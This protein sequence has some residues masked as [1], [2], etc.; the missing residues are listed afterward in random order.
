MLPSTQT[1]NAT[2]YK[3]CIALNPENLDQKSLDQPGLQLNAGEGSKLQGHLMR[4]GAYTRGHIWGYDKGCYKGPRRLGFVSGT[5]RFRVAARGSQGKLG[6][7]WHVWLQALKPE[8]QGA[9]G[10]RT[11]VSESIQLYYKHVCVDGASKFPSIV[12]ERAG[13]RYGP[14]NFVPNP[15]TPRSKLNSRK[16]TT[17]CL[18]FR[19][20][21]SRV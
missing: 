7:S 20:V 1:Q 2:P 17:F 19:L 9:L 3:I 15:G 16:P 21:G 13:L 18:G 14:W 4:G 6:V 8:S 10:F 5:V 12:S 11:G